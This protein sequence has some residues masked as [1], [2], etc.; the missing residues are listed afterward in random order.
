MRD[1]R[2]IKMMAISLMVKESGGSSK[3]FL[4]P[5]ALLASF[6]LY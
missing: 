1:V 2:K 4:M 6:T 3:L 5:V